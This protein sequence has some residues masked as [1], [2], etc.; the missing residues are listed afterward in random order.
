MGEKELVRTRGPRRI[1]VVN[2]EEKVLGHYLSRLA[3]IRGLPRPV[4]VVLASTPLEAIDIAKSV[5]VHLLISDYLLPQMNGLELLRR[6]REIRAQ[7]R[8]IVVT[9][10]I[11][12]DVTVYH[13]GEG[14]DQVY[15]SRVGLPVEWRRMRECIVGL[16]A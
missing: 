2:D 6:I 4:S 5:E 11:P 1:L 12:E 3:A 14:F 13:D 7:V 16:L 10:D 9:N 15:P 8:A